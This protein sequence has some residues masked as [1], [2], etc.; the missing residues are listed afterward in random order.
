MDG[1]NLTVEPTCSVTGSRVPITDVVNRATDSLIEQLECQRAIL[2]ACLDCPHFPE[3]RSKVL[4]L[5]PFQKV[6]TLR[7]ALS[8][9]LEET[10]SPDFG[11]DREK[12]AV[13]RESLLGI[14]EETRL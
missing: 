12:M 5:A 8:R 4:E 6:R 14:L 11:Q 3:A 7:Q 9:V 13:L 1:T 2:L 10:A